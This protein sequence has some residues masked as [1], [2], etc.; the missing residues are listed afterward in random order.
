MNNKM[1]LLYLLDYLKENTNEENLANS[2]D[3]IAELNSQ[4]FN[5]DRKT[6]YSDIAA[7]NEM[8]YNVEKQHSSD[9]IGYY[10]DSELFDRVELR[11]LADSIL[12]SHFLSEK[13][14]NAMVEKLMSLTNKHDRK[15]LMDSLNYHSFKS[16]NE[17]VFYNI[18]AIMEAI[19]LKKAIS[20]R[21]FDTD[22]SSKKI[23]RNKNYN[24]VPYA[25][26]LNQERYYVICYYEKYEGFSHY[27]LDK[28][29]SIKAVDTDHLFKEFDVSEYVKSAFSMF[30]GEK[31][32]VTLR[33]RNALA[34]TI[35]DR[36]R[37]N[38]IITRTESDCFEAEIEVM[39]STVFYSWV[40]G[41]NNDIRIIR[42]ES[43]KQQYLQMC[44]NAI[45]K[46][47]GE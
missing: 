1:R 46:N 3:I 7:L 43:V 16:S 9:K 17:Q 11:I 36:F 42:P 34:E 33:C 6:F 12:S 18:D 10:Y 24:M 41:Y 2:S 5:V 8:G 31:T 28:M 21:Y 29:D 27:R 25:L 26:V 35:V 13:K 22:I 45:D 40:F 15:Q 32:A 47:Q 4:G 20:F 37:E 19:R 38:C 23:Y 44:Q 14:S 39:L 30:T